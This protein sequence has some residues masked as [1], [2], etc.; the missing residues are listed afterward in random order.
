[1]QLTPAGTKTLT[2]GNNG[3]TVSIH[4]LIGVG[5]AGRDGS[6][7]LPTDTAISNAINDTASATRA[8][9]SA[10]MG[11]EASTPG[12]PLRTALNDSIAQLAT[13]ARSPDLLV[14]G[15]VTRDANGAATSAP[16]VW[17][18]GQPGTYTA[19]TISTAFPGAV[20]G[21]H[22]TYGSPVTKTFT[23]PTITRDATTGAATNV[24]AIV[25]S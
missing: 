5:P 2:L 7:V 10:T 6:N 14:A 16:V 23:Q 13:W 22:I 19:D 3:G 18:N 21:Y 1:M 11:T 15:T 17:P 12:T 25:V 24:P 9:L 20:D 4:G 8:S